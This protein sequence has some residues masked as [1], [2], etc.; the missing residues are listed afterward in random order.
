MSNSRSFARS[1]SPTILIIPRTSAPRNAASGSAP[2][3]TIARRTSRAAASLRCACTAHAAN[4]ASSGRP[5]ASSASASARR[6]Q[7][8]R[9][10][11]ARRVP[12][13]PS[14]TA[15]VLAQRETERECVTTKT[16]PI[17]PRRSC[18]AAAARSHRRP[19]VGS[20]S[21]CSSTTAQGPASPDESSTSTC[22]VP[23]S[24]TRADGST[25]RAPS[26]SA[27]WPIARSS[28]SNHCGCDRM[29]STIVSCAAL[30]IGWRG[31]APRGDDATH[32]G[33]GVDIP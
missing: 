1:S 9:G 31:V 27:P 15:A 30:G 13:G 25:A 23:G 5:V 28:A 2:I 7:T 3:V 6:R 10:M 16:S 18:S 14:T 29:N 4:N 32:G 21:R 12:C 19:F 26:G 22:T 11:S 24:T 33:N 17:T 8:T 20:S